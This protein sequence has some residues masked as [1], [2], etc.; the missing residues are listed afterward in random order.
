MKNPL[1]ERLA[2]AEAKA[3][4][5][6]QK[7]AA[8]TISEILSGIVIRLLV[9]FIA[10]ILV[11]IYIYWSP[12][13]D[14][15]LSTIL[16]VFVLMEMEVEYGLWFFTYRLGRKT[17]APLQDL[18]K[19]STLTKEGW[20]RAE[21]ILDLTTPFFKWLEGLRERVW[22]DWRKEKAEASQPA[23]QPVQPITSQDVLDAMRRIAEALEA[24]DLRIQALEKDRSEE[25]K[26][27]WGTENLK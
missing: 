1:T 16:L 13:P 20:R 22:P 19:F 27:R 6:R 21:V 18:Q 15:L 2:S 12:L 25:H 26:V 8:M 3:E 10:T 5:A 9:A 23:A 11:C 4:V 14:R 7:Y 24:L 17:E